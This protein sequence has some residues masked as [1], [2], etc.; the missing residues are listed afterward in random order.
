MAL[1]RTMEQ[2]YVNNGGIVKSW[3]RFPE[4]GQITRRGGKTVCRCVGW[5]VECGRL[6]SR[7]RSAFIPLCRPTGRLDLD[8]SHLR[9]E[10]P[11]LCR[12]AIDLLAPHSAMNALTAFSSILSS[13]I[14]LRLLHH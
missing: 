7:W 5:L 4:R 13:D 12:F 10:Y 6:H 1:E 2:V 14:F 9:L 11:L 8:I 3:L